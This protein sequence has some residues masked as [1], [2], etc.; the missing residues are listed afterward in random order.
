MRFYFKHPLSSGIHIQ[1]QNGE[2][3][4]SRKLNVLVKNIVN[5][6]NGY[7]TLQTSKGLIKEQILML[8]RASALHNVLFY[9]H[10]LCLID[11][12]LTFSLARC[13]MYAGIFLCRVMVQ[14]SEQKDRTMAFTTIPLY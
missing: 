3:R 13:Q 5:K 4:S 2:Q 6:G 14:T 8:S 7:E 11:Q 12:T 1:L 10:S 9:A